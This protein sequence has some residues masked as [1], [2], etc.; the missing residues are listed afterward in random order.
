MLLT[1]FFVLNAAADER[2]DLP[3]MVNTVLFFMLSVVRCLC[4]WYRQNEV[5]GGAQN[6]TRNEN[7]SG[8]VPCIPK[9]LYETL[10]N[11]YEQ[12]D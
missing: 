8:T 4:L 11:S 10:K 9:I 7:N 1:R 5:M 3:Q 6:V 12:L 2:V